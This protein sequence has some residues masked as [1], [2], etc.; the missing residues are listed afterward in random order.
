MYCMYYLVYNDKCI[1][2]LYS[3]RYSKLNGYYVGYS[4]PSYDISVHTYRGVYY[5]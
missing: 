2:L 3:I 1:L 5:N 4:I